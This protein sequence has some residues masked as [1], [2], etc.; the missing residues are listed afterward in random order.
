MSAYIIVGF[1]PTNPEKLQQY[2]ASVAATLASYKGEVIARGPVAEQLHGSFDYKMQV[3]LAFP[4]QEKASAW[5]HS[6][7][8]Q[9][10]IPVRDAGMESQF[11]LI[12]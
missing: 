8:Y 5:Y 12:A 2:G 4:S 7:E 11:Q 10:L 9:A 3:V 1:N 6:D